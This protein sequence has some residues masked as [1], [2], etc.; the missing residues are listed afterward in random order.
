MKTKTP[1]NIRLLQA[2]L[3]V[4]GLCLAYIMFLVLQP[5]PNVR[6]E[7]PLPISTKQVT[8]SQNFY[9][10]VKY[11]NPQKVKQK[12]EI[13]LV[14][15]SNNDAAY[16][17]YTLDNRDIAASCNTSKVKIDSGRF[18]AF[19]V[20]DGTYKIRLRSTTYINPIKIDVQFYTSETFTYNK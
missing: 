18:P 16:T 14:D 9:V 2:A 1:F 13:Q 4:A 17:L 12:V 8:G 7:Q 5:A 6:V 19:N 3:V 10:T 20:A 11:C 15:P